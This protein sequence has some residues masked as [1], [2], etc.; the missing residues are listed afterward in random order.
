M[1]DKET[2]TV[3]WFS[4]SKGYGFIERDKGTDVFVHYTEIVGQGYR[5]LE[6]GQRVVFSVVQSEKGLQAQTVTPV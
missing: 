4:D 5:S 2:G 6:K 3:K 1:D